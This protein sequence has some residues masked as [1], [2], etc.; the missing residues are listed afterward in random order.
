MA[1]TSRL[2]MFFVQNIM[3]DLWTIRLL[4]LDELMEGEARNLE[5]VM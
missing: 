4:A 5:L 1:S 2:Q 3:L